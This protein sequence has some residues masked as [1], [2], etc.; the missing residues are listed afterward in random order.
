MSLD[1]FLKAFKKDD[2]N[3]YVL[4]CQEYIVKYSNEI[5]SCLDHLSVPDDIKAVMIYKFEGYASTWIYKIVPALEGTIPIDLLQ[6][7]DGIKILKV[8]LMRIP[9]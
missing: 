4:F 2:W 6:T 5:T 1:V 9:Q 7:E 3:E 8:A